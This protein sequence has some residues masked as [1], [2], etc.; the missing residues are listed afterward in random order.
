[1]MIERRTNMRN[2]AIR[3]QAKSNGVRFWEIAEV[4]GVS[5][6]T[7]TRMLRRELPETEQ[8]KILKIVADLARRKEAEANENAGN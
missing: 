2:V 4:M 6:A 1:M 7:V 3:E 8:R 5:E